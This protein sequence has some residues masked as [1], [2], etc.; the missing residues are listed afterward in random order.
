[1]V[2]R[3]MKYQIACMQK[4]EVGSLASSPSPLSTAR[5]ESSPAMTRRERV[6][7]P[8][9]V[10]KPSTR[11]KNQRETQQDSYPGLEVCSITSETVV[12]KLRRLS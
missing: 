2:G 10:A 7:R 1:M 8:A 12:D 11:V 5:Q 3:E 9:V 4:A 6:P